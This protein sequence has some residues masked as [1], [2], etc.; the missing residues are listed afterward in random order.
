[1]QLFYCCQVVK[2]A[3]EERNLWCAGH[4][5]NLKGAGATPSPKGAVMTGIL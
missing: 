3:P 4:V 1:M 5:V 2:K